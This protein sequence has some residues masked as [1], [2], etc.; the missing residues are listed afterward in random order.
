MDPSQSRSTCCRIQSCGVSKRGGRFAACPFMVL[1][2]LALLQVSDVVRAY[3]TWK[4]MAVP[5]LTSIFLV[6]LIVSSMR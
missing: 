2:V 1:H 5:R 6:A 3:G 4:M